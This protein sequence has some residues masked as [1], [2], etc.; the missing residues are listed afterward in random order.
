MRSVG[1]SDFFVSLAL[2]S[3]DSSD[4]GGD[5]GE[6][7]F[8]LSDLGDGDVG[9]MDRDLVGCSVGLVLGELINV[10]HPLLSVDLNHLSLASLTGSTDHNNLV[11][12]ADG[13]RSDTPLLAQVL[14]ESRG[15]DSLS[16]VRWSGEVSSS[17]L[18]SAAA[19]LNVSLHRT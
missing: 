16:D 9:G 3:V 18:S 12:L 7:V 14:G 13:Q 17:L 19:N 11:V 6:S 5:P 2:S 1:S 4:D 15:H 8:G 10:D